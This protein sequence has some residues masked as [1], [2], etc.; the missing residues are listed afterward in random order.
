MIALL[1]L[2]RVYSVSNAPINITIYHTTDVHGWIYGHRHEPT[3]DADFGDIYSFFSIAKSRAT[4]DNQVYVFD[5]GDNIQGTGLSDATPIAGS[6]I[7]DMMKFIPYDALQ[8]GNHDVRH[9]KS[10]DYLV[11]HYSP[12]WNG[13]YL[14]GQGVY[15]DKSKKVGDTHR[16]IPLPNNQGNVLVMG[17]L[18]N[19]ENVEQHIKVTFVDEHLRQPWFTQAM[20]TDNIRTIVVLC[21]FG[22]T[23]GLLSTVKAAI[24]AKAPKIPVVFLTGHTHRS[25]TDKQDS[26]TY[27]MESGRYTDNIGKISFTLAKQAPTSRSFARLEDSR[28][29]GIISNIDQTSFSQSFIPTNKA[30]LMSEL[31]ITD[32]SQFKT[33][34]GER[35][36]L[37]IQNKFIALGL[38]PLVGCAPKT[39]NN[40]AH[41]LDDSTNLYRL[42]LD[43][44]LPKYGPK[45]TDVLSMLKT[46]EE[47][48]A[49]RQ[50]PAANASIYVLDDGLLRY[51]IYKG[52]VIVD[53]LFTS[54]PFNYEA[55]AIV[56]IEGSKLKTF[57][58]MTYP[59][60]SKFTNTH[61]LTK[62]SIKAGQYYDVYVAY[63]HKVQIQSMLDTLS[64]GEFPLMSTGVYFRPLFVD[65]VRNEM[66]C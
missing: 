43:D 60:G 57:L 12:S 21:H 48:E 46:E 63:N 54:D 65:Y 34:V 64:P 35:M 9:D 44:M 40:N 19:C 11:D 22:T 28:N 14:A 39:Y 59:G 47:R 49:V 38:A 62:Q 31:K 4:D 52:E 5:T 1:I 41:Q 24:R 17:F 42:C 45:R 36:K 55:L 33:S 66:K 27:V 20:A 37:L 30:K 51:P 32:P 25:R 58:G 29:D 23:D 26:E 53:D 15:Y 50:K 16:V 3:L 10:V 13:R 56:A 6:F 18:Y 8:I 2:S 61:L 7:Y